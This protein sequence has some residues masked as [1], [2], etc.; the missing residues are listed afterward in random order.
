MLKDNRKIEHKIGRKITDRKNVPN[1]NQSFLAS[2][3]D[4]E[5]E[6]SLKG[7]KNVNR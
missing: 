4:F 2:K 3:G 7:R 5:K 1:K 6:I